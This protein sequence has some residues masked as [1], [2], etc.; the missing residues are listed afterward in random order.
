[1]A[2][3]L[4][5]VGSTGTTTQYNG[6]LNLTANTTITAADNLLILGDN[7]TFANTIT[8]NGHTLTLN[9]TS[10]TGVT[11]TYGPFPAYTLDDA[12]IYIT[13]TITGAGG[14]TKTGAGTVNLI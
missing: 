1:G 4:A 12:N 13:G 10:A 5:A 14:L 2:G 9:T 6:D 7:N 3:A 11:P 8:T